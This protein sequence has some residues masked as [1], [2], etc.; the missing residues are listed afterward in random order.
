MGVT[1]L[2][3]TYLSPYVVNVPL[4]NGKQLQVQAQSGVLHLALLTAKP[5]HSIK[6]IA[7]P[8]W[9]MIGSL[10]AIAATGILPW[11]FSL[12]QFSYVGACQGA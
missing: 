3:V 7:I 12:K 6:G 5:T 8:S 1:L 11:S 10:T 9:V 2:L 4:A